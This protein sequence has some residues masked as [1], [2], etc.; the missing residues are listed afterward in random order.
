M[1]A[2]STAMRGAM[3]AWQQAISIRGRITVITTLVVVVVLVAASIALVSLQR[4]TLTDNIDTAIH[5]RAG[6]IGALLENGAP[7]QSVATSDDEI[8][9]IQI[10]D[11]SGTL[12]SSSPN[13]ANLAPV[14]TA[15]P[16][17]G[18]SETTRLGGLP[19]DDEPFH[20]LAQT[21]ATASGTHT[22][23]VGGNLEAVEESTDSLLAIL[24]VGVPLLGVAV[25]AGTWILVGRALAP[26]EAMRREVAAIGAEDLGRRVPRPRVDDELGHLA[27]TMNEMLA[28]LQEAHERQEQFT[29]DASHELR[30]PLASMR[31]QL[32]VAI[33]HPESQQ[34]EV[35][36]S[37]LQLEVV[38]MQ[39]LVEQLLFLAG[40]DSRGATPS[41]QPVDLDDIVFE[42]ARRLRTSAVAID[43]SAVSAGQVRGDADQLRRAVRN[44]IENATRHARSLVRIEL[45]EMHGHVLLS[46]ADDGEGIP[47]QARE[48]VF[49]RFTR[50]DDARTRASGGAG[51]GLAITRTIVL[52]HGGVIAVDP[53]YSGGARIV[54]EFHSADGALP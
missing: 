11:A 2:S 51:L 30:S 28:R 35:T 5:L 4:R 9:F 6:D 10:V 16:P 15:R 43:T 45:R 52:A 3:A 7:P 33:A 19:I 22:V 48:R 17:P 47:E 37:D 29:A 54:L 41:Q 18:E 31:T 40:H 23:Y 36:A 13:V 24:R 42:E 12:V 46:V 39:R 50:L 1:V 14:I 53:A 26:V 44:L 38:R 27:Q 21:F 20:V 25:A 8:A 49:E 32:E 34:W